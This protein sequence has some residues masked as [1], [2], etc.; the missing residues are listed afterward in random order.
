MKDFSTNVSQ[1]DKDLKEADRLDPT[2]PVMRAPRG[3]IPP[4]IKAINLGAE[5][6]SKIPVPV[7]A[8]FACPHNF[9]DDPSL[10]NDPKTKAALVASSLFYVSRQADAF[11]AGIPSAR[12]VRLP[13]ADHYVFRSNEAEVMQEMNAFLTKL[14]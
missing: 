8:I 10:K 4:I 7:L 11:A 2:L 1:L 14:P 3:P 12:V 9:D 5:E 6:Y 13:N